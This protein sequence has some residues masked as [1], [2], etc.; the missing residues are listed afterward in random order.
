MSD[1]EMLALVLGDMGLEKL[2][3]ELLPNAS[4]DWTAV[5]EV[6]RFLQSPSQRF[7]TLGGDTGT[8][9]TIAAATA[10][11]HC[12]REPW[13]GYKPGTHEPDYENPQFFWTPQHGR[14]MRA[15]ELAT[16]PTFGPA[17]E[18]RWEK[19]RERKLLVVDDLGAEAVT[20]HWLARL[21]DLVDYRMRGSNKTII[22]TNLPSKDLKARYG[23]RVFRR[24]T[25]RGAFW[26]AMKPGG[27]VQ[28]SLPEIVA[29]EPG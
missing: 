12:C 11:V 23:D 14:F 19:V 6:E 27:G 15:S 7:L 2:E 25:D 29:P 8:G 10:L 3:I 16:M 4:R 28:A 9:K 21:G 24:L 5:D 13:Y 1:D 20:E 17:A 18:K 26:R 22:T